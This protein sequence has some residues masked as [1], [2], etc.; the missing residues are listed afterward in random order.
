MN[1]SAKHEPLVYTVREVSQILRTN[2]SFVYRLIDHDLLPAIK[3]CS[4]RVRKEALDEFLRRYEGCDLSGLPD[5][6]PLPHVS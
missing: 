2:I 3:L 6:K 4:L 1:N 5:I